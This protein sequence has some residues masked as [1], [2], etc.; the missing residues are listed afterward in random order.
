MNNTGKT[1]AKNAS[2]LMGSQIV[3]WSLAILL[4]MFLPR[5]LGPAAIG[6]LHL[7]NS[8]WAIIAI[9]VTFGMDIMMTKEIARSKGKFSE[10]AGTSLVIKL[11]IYFFGIVALSIYLQWANYSNQTVLII[12]IIGVA[13]LI[14]QIGGVFQT[15]LVGNERMEYIAYADIVGKLFRTIVTLALIFMGFGILTVALVVIGTAIVHTLMQVSA[16][17]KL[18][19]I[20]LSFRWDLVKWM[21]KASSPFF[22]VAVFRSIYVQIDV[23][24]ISLLVN[25]ETIGWYSAAD[26]L[27]STF[28]F[29]PAIFLTAAF[30]ALA[31]LY[32]EK[33]DELGSLMRK[34]FDMLMLL[35][36]PIGLGLFVLGTEIVVLIFGSDFENSGTVLSVMGIVLIFTYLNILIGR[37]LIATNR[38]NDWSIVM[39]IAVLVSI[40]LDLILVPWCQTTF[41]N[42]AIGGALAFVVTESGMLLIGIY[43]LPKG[44]LGWSNVW[45]TSRVLLAGIIMVVV[46]WQFRDFF[47]AIPI[48]IGGITFFCFSLLFGVL[49]KEFFTMSRQMGKK[50]L[51]KFRRT[52]AP[53]N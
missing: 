34:S 18:Q 6:Q 44:S 5:Y 51:V 11:I 19:P 20:K 2:F 28:M 4:M 12:V 25:E 37:F 3:T 53:V 52:E 21:L 17:R 46:V 35:S 30:P 29:I 45:V 32:E 26:S 23:V 7:A 24:I 16:A 39:A 38:Q 42:G 8:I 50:I 48:F 43:L 27:F 47:I 40:P 22:F 15:S 10:L 13:N 1:I 41:G 9:F 14:S 36:I 49:P 31:R 33:S